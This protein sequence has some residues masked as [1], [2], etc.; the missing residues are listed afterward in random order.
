MELSSWATAVNKHTNQPLS[1]DLAISPNLNFCLAVSIVLKGALLALLL[2]AY[3]I[4]LRCIDLASAVTTSSLCDLFTVALFAR[5][6]APQMV[7]A[8]P[9]QRQIPKQ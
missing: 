4:A 6:C 1:T 9:K 3:C 7:V 5:R 8:L 2:V